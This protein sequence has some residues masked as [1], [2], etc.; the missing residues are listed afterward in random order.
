M[1]E[2][3]SH[4]ASS[5]KQVSR[6]ALTQ[7]A[8]RILYLL[9]RVALPPF[10]LQHISMEEYGIWTTC[11]LIIGYLGMGAFGVS[12][13][14]IRYVAEYNATHKL[15]KVGPLIGAGLTITLLFSA[16]SLVALWFGLPW[17]YVA[18]KI[19]PH[20]ESTAAILILGS[21]ASML[22]DMTFGAFAYVLQGMQ[23]ITQ[24]TIVWIFSYLLESALMVAFLVLGMGVAGLLWAFIA[25]YALSTLIYVALCY[26]A[27]PGLKIRFRGLGHAT[28][29]L[30]Y[31]YG[32]IMQINGLLSIFLYSCERMVA[33]TL[34]G[35]VS[36]VLLDIGQKFP[37][38]SSQVFSSAN[39][40]F[41]T[42]LTHLHS[43][44]QRDEIR[45]LYLRGS[46]Y[47]SLLNGTAMGFM[48]AF[49]LP[50]VT[51]W[52][53]PDPAYHDSIIIMVCAT[54]GYQWHAQTGTASTYHQGIGRPGRV[55][56]AFTLPQLIFLAVALWVGFAHLGPS[57]LTVVYAALAARILSSTLFIQ[58]TNWMLG[59]GFWR[60]AWQVMLPGITPYGIGFGLAYLGM[61]YIHN[62]GTGRVMLIAGLS[63]SGVLYGLAFLLTFLLLSQKEE[64]LGLKRVLG[65]LGLKSK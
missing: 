58:Y 32:G 9:T 49:A 1:S 13:V 62:L 65:K 33:G 42:A 43:L 8:G 44:D 23:R 12:N 36:M 51:A 64:R 63:V 50:I 27:I 24:Q 22:L 48:A 18:F 35:V 61:E 38:M 19:P 52:M 37:M 34:T 7:M 3:P 57:L 41:L 16:V 40:S 26:R 17:L 56:W 21:V 47:L 30:F 14:Y 31:R 10:I 54:V 60:Y 59:V 4:P 45:R 29:S 2:R 55:L 20:L 5:G 6:N 53:G 39:N 46:R 28:Y 11:F 15:E 25:R